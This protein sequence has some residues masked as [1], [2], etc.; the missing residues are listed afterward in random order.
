[1]TKWMTSSA[2]QSVR[3]PYPA[4]SIQAIPYLAFRVVSTV[5]DDI[6]PGKELSHAK[7]SSGTMLPYN[8]FDRG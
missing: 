2:I 8:L 7:R 3:L 6:Q 4:N 1:M 5:D